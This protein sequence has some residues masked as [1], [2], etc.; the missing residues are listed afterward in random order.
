MQ[1]I[2]N[3]KKL[4]CQSIINSTAVEN[5]MFVIEFKDII[6][7]YAKFHNTYATIHFTTDLEKKINKYNNTISNSIINV[8]ITNATLTS[9][10]DSVLQILT[11]FNYIKYK[12]EINKIIKDFNTKVNNI[13]HTEISV[14]DALLLQDINNE[15]IIAIKLYAN[16]TIYQIQR[17]NLSHDINA[18]LIQLIVLSKQI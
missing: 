14:A 4:I 3:V 9:A 13:S 5:N 17:N 7:N 10:L 8:N 11:D 12:N 1:H 6:T 15:Q 18:E 16:K 2:I